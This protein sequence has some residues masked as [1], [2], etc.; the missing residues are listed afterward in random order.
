MLARVGASCAT[1]SNS[2][3]GARLV[4]LGQVQVGQHRAR[5]DVGRLAA[6]RAREGLDGARAVA[7]PVAPQHARACGTRPTRARRRRASR[8][9]RRGAVYAASSAAHS[10]RARAHG[11]ERAAGPCR[12]GASSSSAR[13]SSARP[14][15]LVAQAAERHVGGSEPQRRRAPRRPR[16][17]RPPR[18]AARPRAASGAASR[19]PRA[20]RRTT[21]RSPGAMACASSSASA[22]AARVAE[23]VGLD[24]RDDHELG[25]HLGRR[26]RAP[27]RRLLRHSMARRAPSPRDA[28]STSASSAARCPGSASSAFSKLSSASRGLPCA[29]FTSPMRA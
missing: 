18:P 11:D 4:A 10:P 2:R 29:R 20:A 7:R 27:S 22:A 21:R 3:H 23:L 9:D 28:S 5:V 1:C 8:S 16:R 19:T 26:C 24:A 25:H 13:S 12:A 6:D 17:G 15:L 14:A